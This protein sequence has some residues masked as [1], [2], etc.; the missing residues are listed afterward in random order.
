V[1]AT[2]YWL[3]Q[4]LRDAILERDD[5]TCGYCGTKPKKLYRRYNGGSYNWPREICVLHVDH[6]VP[7]SKGGSDHPHNLVTACEGC[8]LSKY[9]K[10]WAVPFAECVFCERLFNNPGLAWIEFAA[11]QPFCFC[12]SCVPRGDF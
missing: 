9:D 3:N 8:N 10:T 5:Y 1:T 2:G 6:M 4:R 12:A 11:G 7:R